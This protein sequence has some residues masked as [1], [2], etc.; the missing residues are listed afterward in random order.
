MG[1]NGTNL[2]GTSLTLYDCTI[3]AWGDT[4]VMNT[5]DSLEF[6]FI[7]CTFIHH[8]GT[9]VSA[10]RFDGITAPRLT[11][12]DCVV[13]QTNTGGN[14]TTLLGAF[15]DSN[16]EALTIKGGVWETYGTNGA[17]SG[18]V[19]LSGDWAKLNITGINFTN[20]SLLMT[21]PTYSTPLAVQP[22]SALSSVQYYGN[23]FSLTNLNASAISGTIPDARLSTNVPLLSAN[24]IWGS[25]NRFSGG[26]AMTNAANTVVGTFT[27]N[28]S[29][30]CV[31]S[32]GMVEY[33]TTTWTT[34]DMPVGAFAD[35]NSNSTG[36]IYRSIKTGTTT[37]TNKLL[38]N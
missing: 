14:T 12:V 25:S 10:W 18:Q 29:S 26:V 32:N 15:A 19:L 7:R 22:L 38:L 4:F 24:Q 11:W 21:G 2:A 13:L 36:I 3:H 5:A 23:G 35:W 31:A 34:N 8:V 16:R 27:G 33:R 9:S 1:V 30:A 20:T 17:S 37:L 6:T 28:F